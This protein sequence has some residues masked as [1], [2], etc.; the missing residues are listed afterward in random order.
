MRVIRNKIKG[1]IMK[2]MF[3][4]LIGKYMYCNLLKVG[5]YLRID[6]HGTG[7]NAY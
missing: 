5:L 3:H 2:Q 7:V 4:V 1:S 6:S